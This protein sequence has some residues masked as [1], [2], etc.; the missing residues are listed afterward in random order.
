[1][2][3]DASAPHRPEH[4]RKA[5]AHDRACGA[6][7]GGFN[8][9]NAGLYSLIAHISA[10]AGRK[11]HSH[12]GLSAAAAVAAARRVLI[13]HIGTM[14]ARGHTQLLLA[15]LRFIAPLAAQ[16]ASSRAPARSVFSMRSLEVALM[17]QGAGGRCFNG[18]RAAFRDT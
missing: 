14:A 8:E 12:L 6:V 4:L 9:G 5:R 17:A 11:V 13:S 7:V 1:M 18:S 10:A 16:R 15:R 3:L 2:S